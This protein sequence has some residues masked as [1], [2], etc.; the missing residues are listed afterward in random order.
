MKK[1]LSILAVFF[2]VSILSVS[3]VMAEAYDDCTP[4]HRS[5]APVQEDLI[6]LSDFSDRVGNK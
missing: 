5:T 1:T 4:N 3:S 6:D 2:V